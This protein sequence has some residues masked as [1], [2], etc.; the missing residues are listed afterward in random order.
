MGA[1][2]NLMHRFVNLGVT[3]KIVTSENPGKQGDFVDGRDAFFVKIVNGVALRGWT[4]FPSIRV[5][6]VAIDPRKPKN[7]IVCHADAALDHQCGK[8]GSINQH[9]AFTNLVHEIAG[10]PREA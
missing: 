8:S 4:T 9:D 5:E 10:F 1:F 7:P 2:G 6:V 3:E